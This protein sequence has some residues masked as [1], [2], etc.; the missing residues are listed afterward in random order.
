MRLC[1]GT[2]KP[3]R[4]RSCG[5]WKGARH[6]G[7]WN[8]P[9]VSTPPQE[10]EKV[11]HPHVPCFHSRDRFCGLAPVVAMRRPGRGP[12]SF[13]LRDQPKPQGQPLTRQFMC[14]QTPLESQLKLCNTDHTAYFCVGSCP[15]QLSRCGS[16]I[17]AS[18]C[19]MKPAL[20]TLTARWLLMPDNVS[21][22]TA[23]IFFMVVRCCWEKYKYKCGETKRGWLCEV[24]GSPQFNFTRMSCTANRTLS[25]LSDLVHPKL[26][27]SAFDERGTIQG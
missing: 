2:T 15:D 7:L 6:E 14:P 26:P 23:F 10:Q 5:L 24:C 18:L 1:S 20:E 11:K 16:S 4:T 12:F 19:L 17:R 3:N 9:L 22:H 13:R 25:G 27:L 8:G 21:S